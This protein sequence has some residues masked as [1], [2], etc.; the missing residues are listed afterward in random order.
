[1]N[2]E[3]TYAISKSADLLKKLGFD[4]FCDSA[5][6]T[7]FTHNG[8]QID[9]DEEFEL[10]AEGRGKEIKRVKYGSIFNHWYSNKENYPGCA[11]RPTLAFARKWIRETLNVDIVVAPC[12]HD[13]GDV[14][15]DF[16]SHTGEHPQNWQFDTACE[17]R[18]DHWSL[19]PCTHAAPRQLCR[20]TALA[21]PSSCPPW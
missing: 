18:L 8:E 11:A 9:E 3:E 21:S 2:R 6:C 13:F 19:F 16:C 12:V 15:P 7:A 20:S 17:Q 5:Y 10:K 1:M 4:W 14:V